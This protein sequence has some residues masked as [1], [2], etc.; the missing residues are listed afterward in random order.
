MQNKSVSSLYH[1][2]FQKIM[3]YRTATWNDRKS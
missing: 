3:L 1:I 2:E